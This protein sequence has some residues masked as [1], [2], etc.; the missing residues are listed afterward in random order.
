MAAEP[1]VPI[2]AAYPGD[3]GP[4]PQWQ[5]RGLAGDHFADNLVAR[6]QVRVNRRQVAFRNVQIRAAHSTRKHTQQ[7][8][9]RAHFGSRHFPDLKKRSRRGNEQDRSL[10]LTVANGSLI[11]GSHDF[12]TLPMRI[13]GIFIGFL[14]KLTARRV[15][16]LA[17]SYGSSEV[18][19]AGKIVKF[20]NSIVGALWHS[21]LL[22]PL[23]AEN[24]SNFT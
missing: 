19:M 2:D 20:G 15:I 4:A 6:D 9:S 24:A 18:R 7:H 1:A 12:L 13:R 10:H 21:S 8:I 5:L 16:L 17:M 11:A 22:E 14:R 3:P 23:D